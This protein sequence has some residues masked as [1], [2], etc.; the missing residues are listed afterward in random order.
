MREAQGMQMIL[1]ILP[2]SYCRTHAARVDRNVRRRIRQ[3]IQDTS[4]RTVVDNMDD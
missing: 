3:I 4:D 1:I 2:S